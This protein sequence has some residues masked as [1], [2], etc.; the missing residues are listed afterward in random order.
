MLFDYRFHLMHNSAEILHIRSSCYKQE[1]EHVRQYFQ[2]QYQN[3]IQ[4]NGLK[5]KWWIW[6]S[7]LKEVSISMKYICS[8]LKS[9]RRGKFWKILP[10]LQAGSKRSTISP[11][12]CVWF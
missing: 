4:L 6:D 8:Y 2:K 3:W 10:I 11:S 5:S 9:T 1:A 12:L 7:I